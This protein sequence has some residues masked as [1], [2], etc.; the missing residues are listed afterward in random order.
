MAKKDFYEVLGVN[1]SADE[2]TIRKAYRKL[3]KKYHP[4]SNPGD[5]EAEKRFKEVTEAYNVLSD[6]EKKKLYD[7]FGMAAFEE[8]ASA[9]GYGGYEDRGGADS[10]WRGSSPGGNWQEMHFHTN[11]GD[12]NMD[13]ILKGMFGGHAGGFSYNSGFDGYSGFGGRTGPQKGRDSEADLT[14][15]FDEAA[16][17]ADKTIT[18]RRDGKTDSLQ[19]HIPAGIEDG[20]KIRLR[21]KG[22]AG[23][24]GGAPGDLLLRVHVLEKPGFTRK[25]MDVYTTARI[26]Y[27][28]AVLG[29]EAV[30]DTLQGK[31][32][33]KVPAGTQ[34]GSKIRLSG[35]GIVSMKNGK[36]RGDQYVTIEIDV[37]RHIS[38]Q[39]GRKLREYAALLEG[40]TGKQSA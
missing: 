36:T 34:S 13:D 40:E 6:K 10:F 25:G 1:R 27:T 14:V 20:K 26:P 37:P 11:S 32:V 29:G 17:G 23:V 7:Q 19:V 15:T 4:D 5:K 39:A 35:K 22:G 9:G 18:L 3:A 8:G 2:Q 24:G 33:C 16:F 21:G 38:A 31:V 28:T 30:V 12:V